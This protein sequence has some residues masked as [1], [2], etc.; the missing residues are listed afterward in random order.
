VVQSKFL[1]FNGREKT[2][3]YPEGENTNNQNW[4]FFLV[5]DLEQ[6]PSLL[7]KERCIFLLT[8]F[9]MI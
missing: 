7:G 4:S 8:F 5:L 1:L 6:Q 3:T 9:F 2:L